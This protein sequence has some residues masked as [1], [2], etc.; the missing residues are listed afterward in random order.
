MISCYLCRCIG[1]LVWCFSFVLFGF[2]CGCGYDLCVWELGGWWGLCVCACICL[3]LQCVWKGRGLCVCAYVS[4][5]CVEGG[6]GGLCLYA[7]MYVCVSRVCVESVCVWSL[8]MHVC[9]CVCGGGGLYLCACLCACVSMSIHNI[10]MC[11]PMCFPVGLLNL[12]H[13]FLC[14][15]VCCCF[16]LLL[17]LL[18]SL[19]FDMHVFFTVGDSLQ[20][21]RLWMQWSELIFISDLH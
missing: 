6:G 3:C 4:V 7:C 21:G 17:L 19:Y 14:F 11:V 18:L 5:V 20:H 9:V 13:S 15:F 2:G 10:V 1:C 8:C 16:F 12:L